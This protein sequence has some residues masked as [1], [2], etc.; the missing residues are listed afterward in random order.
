MLESIVYEADATRYDILVAFV[1]NPESNFDQQYVVTLVNF[2]ECYFDTELNFIGQIIM[3]K[4][5][6]LSGIDAQNIQ[7]AIASRFEGVR[8]VKFDQSLK[9]LNGVN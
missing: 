1:D 2:G 4:S 9:M 5:S 3:N 8:Q 6:Q 7:N